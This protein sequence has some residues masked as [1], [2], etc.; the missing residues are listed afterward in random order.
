MVV[1]VMLKQGALKTPWLTHD[2]EAQSHCNQRGSINTY[3]KKH[4]SSLQK[5]LQ[6]VLSSEEKWT[7]LSHDIKLWQQKWI[8]RWYS[9][10]EVRKEQ[11]SPGEIMS[12]K[13]G[14]DT[15]K[16]N[17]VNV[18]V[19][20]YEY[21]SAGARWT[22]QKYNLRHTDERHIHDV[23]S[24]YVDISHVKI[25]WRICE[26]DWMRTYWFTNILVCA[27]YILITS[28]VCKGRRWRQETTQ[29]KWR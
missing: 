4:W 9:R 7:R 6:C 1:W 23:V 19:L 20:S 2:D 5:H 16:T 17:T 12:R 8:K 10:G 18:P 13:M 22:E 25:G 3:S 24:N 29:G 21:A 28:S 27:R 26:P 14:L 15:Q 11:V